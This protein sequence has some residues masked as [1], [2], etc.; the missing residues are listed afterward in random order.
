M[1]VPGLLQKVKSVVQQVH[2][3]SFEGE[4]LAVDASSWLHK[5]V[6]SCAQE[7]ARGEVTDGFLRFPLTMVALFQSHGIVPLLVFDGAS[8]P[9]KSPASRQRAEMRSKNRQKALELGASDGFEQEAKAAMRKAVGVT[10]EMARQLIV[11]LRALGVP[12]YV[13]PYEADPQLAFLVREGHAA[14]AV[15]EDSDLIPYGCP[16]VLFK[17]DRESA[18][19]DLIVFD[20]LR[21]V[22]VGG[23]HLFDGEYE[24]EWEAWREGLLCAMCVLAGNDYLAS[25]P[26][27]GIAK[28]HAAVRKHR[29]LGVAARELGRMVR[30]EPDA[31]R[32]YAR[33]AC[34]VELV[35]RHHLVFDPTSGCVRPLTPLPAGVPSPELPQTELDQLIGTMLSPE[36]ARRVCREGSVHPITHE[37]FDASAQSCGAQS[38]GATPHS[39]APSCSLSAAPSCKR[40]R[41]G[42]SEAELLSAVGFQ[43]MASHV[44]QTEPRP[45]PPDGALPA[46]DDEQAS[47]GDRTARPAGSDPAG[48]A[49]HKETEG[50]TPESGASVASTP[51]AEPRDRGSDDPG[52]A[53]VWWSVAEWAAATGEESLLRLLAAEG[54]GLAVARATDAQ[55]LRLIHASLSKWVFVDGGLEG[56][57]APPSLVRSALRL[58]QLLRARMPAGHEHGAPQEAGARAVG[59]YY[60]R[61]VLCGWRQA[62]LQ[63]LREQPP[64]WGRVRSILHAL[65]PEAC[66]LRDEVGQLQPPTAAKDSAQSAAKRHRAVSAFSASHPT[67]EL[68]RSLADLLPAVKPLLPTPCL[69]TAVLP[70]RQP[71]PAPP[72][73]A[74]SSL[75]AAPRGGPASP[76][77]RA[78]GEDGTWHADECCVKIDVSS[79]A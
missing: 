72:A 30:L 18:R 54:S 2:L 50:P 12:Y 45:P 56:A 64:A 20:D 36:L 76:P 8:L 57:A 73:A 19:A 22:E 55:S 66:A 17:L 68:V 52:S 42:G 58:L 38:W 74:A 78:R 53:G 62:L 47:G 60:E 34:R 65:P 14:A 13:A 59:A 37:P 31:S 46:A 28:A 3:S 33:R 48:D 32:D 1:G 77:A 39:S 7:L 71:A 10:P 63:P 70:R 69:S 35:Y 44:E 5:G 67:R 27:V 21:A 40:R 75:E 43:P 11:K 15:S 23:K 61:A 29:E 79:L 9:V 16:C 4:T 49:A 51:A 25:L 41:V 6:L 24:G 26:Q